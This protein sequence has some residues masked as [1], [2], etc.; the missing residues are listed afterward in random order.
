MDDDPA[1]PDGDYADDDDPFPGLEAE[2]DGLAE[3]FVATDAELE[4]LARRL[5]DADEPLGAASHLTHLARNPDPDADPRIG[6]GNRLR[7]VYRAMRRL[8]EESADEIEEI[9]AASF[10]A[11]ILSTLKSG[12]AALRLE[13]VMLAEAMALRGDR[14]MAALRAVE[15]ESALG[16]DHGQALKRRAALLLERL[17]TP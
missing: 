2:L 13:T 17:E 9:Y 15:Q 3:R 11:L 1:A 8:W 6:A 16:D 12:D 5:A 7:A 10:E 14:L 4:S